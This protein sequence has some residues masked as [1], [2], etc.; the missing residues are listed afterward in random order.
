M[1]F[2]SGAGKPEL[3][4]GVT[5]TSASAASISRAQ[6]SVCGLVYLPSLGCCGS[7]RNGRLISARSSTSTRS[8]SVVRQADRAIQPAMAG[9]L[10]PG[11]VDATMIFRVVKGLDLHG[12]MSGLFATQSYMNVQH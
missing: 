7:S 5:I 11:R 3:Y 1:A 2:F 4:S 8:K 10:L 6:A 12:L 9:P